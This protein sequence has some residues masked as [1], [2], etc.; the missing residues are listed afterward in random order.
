MTDS[1]G[2]AHDVTHGV[3]NGV[4]YDVAIV[5]GGPAGLV[6]ARYCLHA[7]LA[8][9]ILTPDL[10]GKVNYPFAIR[11]VEAMDS[12]WGAQLVHDFET[13]VAVAPN[14]AHIRQRAAQVMVH[15]DGGY[16]IALDD[17]ATLRTRTIIL[18]T[19]AAPQRMYVA[20]EKEYWGR[21]VSF[22]AI[23]HAPFFVGRDVAVVGG[24]ERTLVAALELASI[25]RRVFLVVSR[26]KAMAELP[27]ADLVRSQRNVT[28]FENWEVQQIYGD[29]FV[30]GLS[31]VGANGETRQL[32]VEGVFVQLALLPNN[33]LVRDMVDVDADG[34]IRV[35][36]RC[37]TNVP[38]IFAA[39]DVTNI[40]SEQVI[41]AV[42]EGAKA[43]LSAWE[44][45]ATHRLPA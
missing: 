30:T 41:V 2:V 45:L 14:L 7:R 12:V 22:S 11:G 18:A 39:G 23:S 1:H 34:H 40:Q 19:G 16:Q 37:E 43:A 31:L 44:Y 3:T 29:D 8:T 33:E 28:A 10:G 13:A 25:A 35:N 5:G 38:G 27:I 26:P 4:I 32:A 6:A 42:G 24:G 36:Q 15:P 17:G 9:S 21:G 20:G